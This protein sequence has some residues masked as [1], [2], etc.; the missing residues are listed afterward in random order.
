MLHAR[1]SGREE[2]PATRN[3]ISSLHPVR[4]LPGEGRGGD[5]IGDGCVF[6]FQLTELD[7]PQTHFLHSQ[8]D[9]GTPA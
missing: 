4:A 2:K 6:S 5:R 3:T 1:S 7:S 9:W 8:Q